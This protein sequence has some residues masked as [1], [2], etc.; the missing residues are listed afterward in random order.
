MIKLAI[1]KLVISEYTSRRALLLHRTCLPSFFASLTP[2][3]SPRSISSHPPCPSLALSYSRQLFSPVSCA[4]LL[5]IKAKAHRGRVST[6]VADGY[7]RASALYVPR[8]V[9]LR[10]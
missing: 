5:F 2:P 9:L 7:A 10:L 8:L 4:N 6:F 3:L 1:I